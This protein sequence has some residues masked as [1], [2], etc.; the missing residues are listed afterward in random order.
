MPVRACVPNQLE[1]KRVGSSHVYACH[2]A[3]NPKWVSREEEEKKEPDLQIQKIE[4][5]SLP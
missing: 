1:G 2:S 5:P 3:A 4:T